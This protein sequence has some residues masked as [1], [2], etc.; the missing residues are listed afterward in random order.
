MR[1]RY[2]ISF[3][4]VEQ[5]FWSDLPAAYERL[6][7]M[8][9]T[10]GKDNQL[11]LAVTGGIATGKSTVSMILQDLV[12]CGQGLRSGHGKHLIIRY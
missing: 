2:P 5:D 4:G 7:H 6:N 10:R 8:E 3:A 12:A 11:L 9:K 1:G